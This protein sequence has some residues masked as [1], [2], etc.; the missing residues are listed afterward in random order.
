MCG[1]YTLG[2]PES[3]AARYGFQDFHETKIQPRF[4]IAPSQV[5]PVI[6]GTPDGPRPRAMRWGFHPAWMHEPKRPPPINA[7]VEGL[8]DGRLFRGALRHGRCAIPA[9]GFYE[10]VAVPGERAKRPIHICLKGGGLFVFAGLSTTAPDG[11]ETCA[12]IT[13]SANELIAPLHERMPVILGRQDEEV[14]L[15]P[16]TDP[17]HALDLLRP[18]PS[19]RMEAYPV[20]PLVS[21]VLND[22]PELIRRHSGAPRNVSGGDG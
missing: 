4:N 17:G 12:I 15:D 13:T 6:V 5:V 2:D 14:W 22:G 3:I 9:D 16:E 8:A 1:R 11:A 19:E 10:W 7:R 18:F 21:S 20:S